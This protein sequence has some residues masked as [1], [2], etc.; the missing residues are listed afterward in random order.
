MLRRRQKK[1]VSKLF[2]FLVFTFS[3]LLKSKGGKVWV[4]LDEINTSEHLPFISEIIVHHRLNGRKLDENLV[5]MGACNPYKKRDKVHTK[6][7]MHKK[8]KED[9]LSELRYR[10]FPLLPNLLE[11]IFD[12]G[13]INLE[14]QRLYVTKMI[15]K[16]GLSKILSSYTNLLVNV[17][18]R[19]Q[20][21]VHK[22]DV[23]SLRDVRR[24]IQLISWFYNED[25]SIPRSTTNDE[26]ALRSIILG[27][28]LSYYVRY[29]EPA[30]RE[31][32]LVEISLL[33]KLDAKRLKEI[34][35]KGQEQF[36]STLVFPSGVSKN[37]RLVENIWCLSISII[38]RIPVL[39]VGSPGASKTLVPFYSSLLFYSF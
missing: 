1:R 19:S 34:V 21:L 22:D 5:F 33:F 24:C 23:V 9:P 15:E 20:E 13:Q 36:V 32:Y 39:L 8:L 38:N 29:D 7:L 3:P 25:P 37:E 27:L 4:F 10:V 35:R 11:S 26:K 18:T 17:L 30:Q 12:F 28:A 16:E 6:G 2:L 14:N 31:R